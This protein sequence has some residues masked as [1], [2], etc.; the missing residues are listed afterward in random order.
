MEY[1]KHTEMPAYSSE[2]LNRGSQVEI[3]A[4][5]IRQL[6]LTRCAALG[7]ENSR[8]GHEYADAFRSR[9]GDVKTIGAIQELH[10]ARR[11]CVARR[12]HGIDHNRCFLAL[13]LIDR[14]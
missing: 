14:S 11:V 7:L 12:G 6:H 2:I 13:E 5:G 4:E 1:V 3:S 8:R 9:R 10:A